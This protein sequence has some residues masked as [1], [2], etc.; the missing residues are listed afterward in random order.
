MF[1]VGEISD[2]NAGRLI[3]HR[4]HHNFVIMNLYPYTSGHLMVAPYA[5]IGDLSQAGPEQLSEMM[6]LARESVAGLD[7]I[8]KP[9]GYN[10]GMNLGQSAGVGKRPPSSSRRASLARR[11]ELHDRH[12]GNPRPARRPPGCVRKIETV[13]RVV[14]RGG[15]PK[16]KVGGRPGLSGQSSCRDCVFHAADAEFFTAE[17]QTRCY[18]Q[19]PRN[20]RNLRID[21]RSLRG[22]RDLLRKRYNRPIFPRF[23]VE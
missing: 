11:H 12:G 15:S 22:R 14:T 5:H 23:F 6:S 7:E 18:S 9:E 13:F 3:L 16:S 19:N 1:C 8:Y 2:L 4:G 17:A 20:P 10:I 21:S